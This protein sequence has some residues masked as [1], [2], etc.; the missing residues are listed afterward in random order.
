MKCIICNQDTQQ[1]FCPGCKNDTTTMAQVIK[2]L[3]EKLA[4]KPMEKLYND[5]AI[6]QLAEFEYALRDGLVLTQEKKDEAERLC[7]DIIE[8]LNSPL[9]FIKKGATK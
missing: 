8:L 5:I 2:S 6:E 1:D 7:Q 4:K 9:M 3:K